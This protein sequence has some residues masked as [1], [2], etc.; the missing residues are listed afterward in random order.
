MFL[1]GHD[2]E[3][4]NTLVARAGSIDFLYQAEIWFHE[5]LTDSGGDK[6]IRF[7]LYS[8]PN[9]PREQK[10]HS[11]SVVAEWKVEN[12]KVIRVK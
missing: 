10:E 8:G 1:E 6:I 2:N 9:P 11:Q 7:S 5:M 4:G 12:G 3:T